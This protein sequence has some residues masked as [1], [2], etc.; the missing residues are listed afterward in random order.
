MK[1]LLL[2]L[3]CAAMFAGFSAANANEPATLDAAAMDG[4]TAAGNQCNGKNRHKSGDSQRVRQSQHGTLSVNA[5][6]SNQIAVGAFQSQRQGDTTNN[7]GN[8][9]SGTF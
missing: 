7:S 5:L 1:K 4:I 3:A 8:F 9:N 6:N 2:P